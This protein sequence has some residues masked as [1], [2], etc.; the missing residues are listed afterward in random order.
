MVFRTDA[1]GRL[2]TDMP[3]WRDITGQTPEDLLGLGWLEGVHPDDRDRVAATWQEAVSGQDLF[4]IEYRISGATVTRWMDV[5]AAPVFDEHGAIEEWIG[6]VIDVT[7]RREAE[8]LHERLQS[9][10]EFE[11]RTLEQV[12]T[13]SSAAVAVLWGPDHEYR[14]FNERYADLIPPGRVLR[15]GMTVAEALPE[16]V[17]Y[18]VPLLNAVLQGETITR[19]ELAI[20]FDDARS[21]RGHRYYD[22]TYSPLV[23]AGLPVGVLVVATESTEAVRA[24]ETLERQLSAE[25][26]VA[27]QLQRALLPDRLPE[28]DGL[29]T[30]VEYLPAMA[31]VGV[32]GDWYDAVRVDVGRV[33]L[34]IGDVGGRGLEAATV[35]SQLR[36][37]VRAYA[38]EVRSPGEILS[39]V[40]TYC[41]RL[42]LSDLVT[43]AIG[44]LDLQERRLSVASAGHLPPLVVRPGEPPQFIELPGDPPLGTGRRRFRER[45]VDLPAGSTLV[46]YTDGLVEERD[47]SLADSLDGL[48]AA[49]AGDDA[50]GSPE[51]LRETLLRHATA[52]RPTSD[53]VA[54]MVCATDP[55]RDPLAVRM[56]AAPGSVSLA[57]TLATRRARELGADGELMDAVRLAVSEAATNAVLHAAATHMWVGVRA[58]DGLLTVTVSDDGHGMRPRADSPGV[59]LGLP[60]VTS[61]AESFAIDAGPAGGTEV[62]MGFRLPA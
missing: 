4:V 36:S 45:E 6:R 17:Q 15:R 14:L 8:H 52:G 53:D 26:G 54:L 43:V 32:G 2:T 28:L 35:M 38:V 48:R 49:V 39:R 25:R 19:A 50:H 16:A 42:D 29:R 13:Q 34:V 40:A 57:R 51:A 23:E 55:V 9:A 37:A 7:A 58:H 46:L 31:D 60:I 33:L 30:A 47:R 20:P 59:G 10:L 12:V 61:L 5:R 18:A 27:E 24:R 11:R 62:R 41:E 1:A 44:L 56:R 21:H 22:F 3:L